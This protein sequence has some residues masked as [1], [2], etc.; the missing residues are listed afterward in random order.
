MHNKQR[1]GRT[2]AAPLRVL[3]P[4]VFDFSK[5][6]PLPPG[7]GKT[8]VPVHILP[9]LAGEMEALPL[10]RLTLW[11]RP[12]ATPGGVGADLFALWNTLDH[13]DRQQNGAGLR[14]ADVRSER[15]PEGEVIQMDLALAGTGISE[16]SN[17]LRDAV[18]NRGTSNDAWA[19]Q[20]F[21]RF[22]AESIAA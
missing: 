21:L 22:S 7:L 16:R 14:P 3:E 10:V 18:N 12:G 6:R 5:G 15:T 9:Q 13:I 17:R 1:F 20:S 19:G 4:L 2:Q 8:H 11:L